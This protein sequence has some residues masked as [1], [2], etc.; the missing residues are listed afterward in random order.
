MSQLFTS[1]QN[2]S[3]SIPV[4]L[5]D[6][7]F[8]QLSAVYE[9]QYKDFVVL[10]WTKTEIQKYLGT[11]FPRSFAESLCIF[12]KY[13]S[14]RHEEYKDIS[15]LSLFD[16]GCGTGGEI[17]GFILA[18]SQ[19]IPHI[20][21]INV[22]AV[23]GNRYALIDLERVLASTASETCV[24]INTNIIPL[25][26]DDFYDMEI[27]DNLITKKFDFIIS[28]KAISEFV[29]KQQFNTL[30]PYEYFLN[31]FLPK[32][33]DVGTICVADVSSFNQISKEW[34]PI[35]MDNAVTSCGKA[36]MIDR[37]IDF[38]EC[39][40]I[41]HSKKANDVSNI[42]WR[43][44]KTKASQPIKKDSSSDVKKDEWEEL[45]KQMLSFF[46]E[47]DHDSSKD[48]KLRLA[49]LIEAQRQHPNNLKAVLEALLEKDEWKTA[50]N[51][52]PKKIF[53]QMHKTFSPSEQGTFF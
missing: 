24:D 2:N 18:V 47:N 33:S 35:M 25:K 6:L 32:L 26:I 48:K 10:E 12:S 49:S 36:D 29:T 52:K 53:H 23:D 50:K 4:W 28:F 20:K 37:N 3:V 44:L 14:E 42:F 8:S 30:N 15:E 7:I 19:K 41:S 31:A 22:Y 43:I 46:D 34:L 38:N 9:P 51:H 45:C 11:Y 5:D 13:F 27:L 39:Y 16:F 40:Y 17:V 21:T 1:V